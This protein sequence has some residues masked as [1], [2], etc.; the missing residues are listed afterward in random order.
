MSSPTA[1]LHPTAA[2]YRDQSARFAAVLDG[3][4]A[5]GGR[6]DAPT[7]CEGW[8]VRDVVAHVVDTE[9]E[10]LERHD[11][12]GDLP[13]VA[14]PGDGAGDGTGDPAA[15]WRTW[16]AAVLG[17]LTADGVAQR[18]FDGY[19][20]PTT[21]GETL[22]DFYAWDLVVH[23]WDVARATGQDYPISDAEAREVGARADG[24]GDA[25][26]SPGVCAGPVAVGDDASEA[27]RLLAR[28]GRNPYWTAP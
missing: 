12:A 11:L 16:S 5:A 9:R 15:A 13:A 21:I 26:Y 4:A 10:F 7:P 20:G 14:V 17:V 1:A 18:P 8:T 6:W 25:L 2:Y 3:V 24:W 28:L 27:E 19:F 23:G 22:R